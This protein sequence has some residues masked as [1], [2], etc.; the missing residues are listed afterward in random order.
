MAARL[1][2]AGFQ[3]AGLS[4]VQHDLR[5]VFDAGQGR[6]LQLPSRKPDGVWVLHVN[7]P[8]A[9]AALATVDPIAWRGRYRIGYWA[10]ELPRLPADWVKASAA[11]HEI[12]TPSQFV[13]DAAEAAGIT[14]PI[15]VMPHPVSLAGFH[16]SRSRD[17]FAMAE[18][19]F[20]VLAMGDLLSSA[21]RK[22]MVGAIEIFRRAFPDEG[23]AR[24]LIKTQ[25]AGAHPRFEGDARAAAEGRSDIHFLPDVM[26]PDEIADLIAS[27]DLLLSPHRAEGFGLPIAEAFLAGV[28][29]LATGW[30]GN[31]DFMK[32]VPELLIANSMV[33]VNDPYR[34]Y[35]AADLQWAE[36][37]M[38]DAVK[39]VRK[40]VASP[41][42]RRSLA[43]RG[44]TA[45]EALAASWSTEALR[46]MPWAPL[47]DWS[48]AS[49]DGRPGQG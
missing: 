12:W 14:K 22:N 30:S 34:I 20:V 8:E 39:K 42:L 23:V 18:D 9:I 4:P 16:G 44:R 32:E 31:L 17:R 33:P 1:S 10:Y 3:S 5:S 48:S 46:Q 43:K 26:S 2:I 11:F 49:V 27:A 37:D 40:L 25:S 6:R 21:A 28:P 36:P 47:V 13:A 24:L 41:D 7:A 15:R 19:K 45:V 35:K 29:A 38:E